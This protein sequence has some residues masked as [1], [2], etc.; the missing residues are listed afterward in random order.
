MSRRIVTPIDRTAFDAAR[1]EYAQRHP[2]EPPPRPGTSLHRRRRDEW[3]DLYE[4]HGGE[5]DDG[6]G[7]QNALPSSAVEPCPIKNE[8][9]SVEILDGGPATTL[10]GAGTQHVNLPRRAE[11]VC[12]TT[13]PNVDRMGRDIRVK[14]TFR[15]PKKEKF[16]VAL[17]AHR[18]DA[19]YSAAEQARRASFVYQR[20]AATY[21][22][23]D[24]VEHHGAVVTGTTRSN[25]TAVVE[26]KLSVTPAGGD[27]YK[28]VAWDVNGKV[29]Y[30]SG[31]IA[32][33]RT[34]FY[35]TFL[36]DDPNHFRMDQA[37]FRHGIE[38]K[39]AAQHVTL[40]F[41]G[42]NLLP[43]IV[44]H[45]TV[46]SGIVPAGVHAICRTRAGAFGQRY[47]TYKPYLIRF[48]FVDHCCEP[49]SVQLQPHAASGV[50]P[51]A[52][53]RLPFYNNAAA[54]RAKI[55][56]FDWRKCL[57]IGLGD[58]A[59]AVDKP[60]DGT[61]WFR[62]ASLTIHHGPPRGD[63]V[64]ALTSADFALR[65]RTP[66][67]GAFV[68]ATLDIGTRVAAPTDVTISLEAVIMYQSVLG[69]SLSD[70]DAG[71]TIQ[72]ARNYFTSVP[73][74]RQLSSAIHECGHAVGMCASSL[75]Q[76]L[77]HGRFYDYNGQHCWTGVATAAA[78]PGD[79]HQPPLK[80]TGTCVMYG[81][82][83][84]HGPNMDFCPACAEVLR[85][86]DL[87]GGLAV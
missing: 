40:V 66:G 5:V 45:D 76:G 81:L 16:K 83:P 68:E 65:E 6:A 60:T 85:K 35:A 50:G 32:T 54:T 29:V 79:Y 13:V 41:L 58:T 17:L 55:P 49:R 47:D 62:S 53:I 36:G 22:T 4:K 71:I 57:W 44:Y 46:M 1:T 38:A 15:R 7:F 77:E 11:L 8:I 48:V 59:V 86:I 74:V 30:S 78:T 64:V 21:P 31:T 84:D 87:G 33:T 52:K 19:T 63:E 51:N 9:V 61:T 80:D 10:G 72:P 23:G 56:T 42:E 69:E 28:V 26:G 75:H 3:L 14:V 2:L 37:T 67:S 82:I 34:I 25:G 39:Y 27:Q 20:H 70:D 24:F 43:G 18:N 12:G 73:Q